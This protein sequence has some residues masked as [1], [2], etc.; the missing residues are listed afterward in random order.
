M[1]P[2]TTRFSNAQRL[3]LPAS[4]ALA[5]CFGSAAFAADITLQN[6]TV[7][8]P[9]GKSS[10]VMKTVEAKGTNL[11]EAELKKLFT[12]ATP[13]DERLAITSK[14][15]AESLSIPSIEIIGKTQ[16]TPGKITIQG[17]SVTGISEGKFKTAGFQGI[18]G[19]IE[20]K[21]SGGTVTV[22]SGPMNITDGDVSGMLAA[23]MKNGNPEDG[24]MRFGSAT[25]K[26]FMVRFPEKSRG[27][28]V[29]HTVKMAQASGETKYNGEVPV[30]STGKIEGLVFEPAPNSKPGMSMKMFGYDRINGS[31]T[32]AGTYDPSNKAMKL[33]DYTIAGENAGSLKVTADFGNIDKTVFTG[34]ARDRMA[35]MMGGDVDNLV[36]NFV[37]QGLFDKAVA[38]YG[39]MKGKAA[40]AVKQ[41]WAGMVGGMLPMMLGGSPDAL[42]AANAVTDFIKNPKNITI[43]LSGKAGPL[44]F[45]DF[46]QVRNPMQLMQKINIDAQANQ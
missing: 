28:V 21:K 38:F 32:F 10:V 4:L 6:V 27:K 40:D 36:V 30:S 24:T 7:E 18:D 39:K 46:M 5:M 37:N 35:G 15:K 1:V 33:T 11:T 19:E 23:V 13:K 3:V 16:N 31:I 42:K 12:V 14:M 26:D 41:E 34:N 45:S 20:Q 43:A 9:N 44:K 2:Q 29:Y 25:W 8:S 17:A 22:K